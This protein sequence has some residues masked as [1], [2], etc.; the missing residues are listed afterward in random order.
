MTLFQHAELLAGSAIAAKAVFAVGGQIPDGY[1]IEYS[2]DGDEWDEIEEPK[3]LMD[4][5]YRI[6]MKEPEYAV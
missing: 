6:R 2:Y 1:K 4:F 3:F 5:Y